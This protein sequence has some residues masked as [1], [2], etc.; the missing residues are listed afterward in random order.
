MSAQ[1]FCRGNNSI[2]Y[3]ILPWDSKIFGFNVVEVSSIAINDEE[4]F[5]NFIDFFEDN[6]RVLDGRMICVK[7]HSENVHTLYKLQTKGYE[8][9]E[10]T[11]KPYIDDMQNLNI[12]YDHFI[13]YPLKKAVS[14]NIK[15]IQKIAYSTIKNDRF[16]IDGRFEK[17]KASERYSFWVN[18]SY[19]SGE[20]VLYLDI[21]GSIAGFSI[22][23]ISNGNAHLGLIGLDD[24]F[25]AKGLGMNLFGATCQYVKDRGVKEFSTSMSLNNPGALKFYSKCGFTFKDP[26]YVLHKW[27]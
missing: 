15:D 3:S 26:M 22:V 13:K 18:N 9:I 8:F 12:S 16:H 5:G 11:I 10:G 19:E 23:D 4:N 24:A 17:A 6:I 25:K 7:I 2:S 20:D 21:N 27:F 14:E 1:E